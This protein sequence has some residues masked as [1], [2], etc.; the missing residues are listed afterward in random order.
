MFV[1]R[2]LP[3]LLALLALALV[4]ACSDKKP[5]IVEPDVVVAGLQRV[6][7]D[8]LSS[9]V[10]TE[11]TRLTVRALDIDGN[12]VSGVGVRFFIPNNG[13]GELD[14]SLVFT[15]SDGLATSGV[16]TLGTRS[17]YQH[18]RVHS[19]LVATVFTAIALPEAAVGI[20]YFAGNRQVALANTAVK[21][22]PAV[23]AIDRFG[24]GVPNVPVQFQPTASSVDGSHAITDSMGVASVARWT[25]GEA[26]PLISLV[27]TSPN[28][29]GQN[30]HFEA[31]VVSVL[32]NI[33]TRELVELPPRL[34]QALDRAI[35]RWMS[36]LS[37]HSGMSRAILAP[38]G[39]GPGSPPIDETITDLM[40]MIRHGALDGPG[41]VLAAAAPCAYHEETG[42]P[43]ISRI[44]FDSADTR[45]YMNNHWIDLIA[46]HELAHAL[47]FGSIW[48][49]QGLLS[50]MGTTDPVFVGTAAAREFQSSISG[51]SGKLVP[52]ENSG[53]PGTAD[54]HWR[55]TVFQREIM[56]G[57][58][59]SMFSPLSRIT[60]G[61]MEDMG[62]KVAY[63]G[64]DP[65]P[66][67]LASMYDA[68]PVQ[69]KHVFGNPFEPVVEPKVM[70]MVQRMRR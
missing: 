52:L 55:S 64:A 61:A 60:V 22:P 54:G 3:P 43:V 31:R 7:G 36:V 66:S 8:S 2:R 23:R 16:W 20:E 10:G 38:G 6:G 65:Y 70:P 49:R 29:P 42:L 17:G 26:S 40:V 32:Y 5:G 9:I 11:H 1:P 67:V 33:E 24:N 35:A 68:A 14:T 13:E 34:R 56:T 57:F 12:P 48:D 37:D 21:V 51:Y 19:Q 62:Y 58:V 63:E 69:M 30:V 47:G 41:G 25:L 28:F 4:S 50:G 39:C 15:D 45:Q 59:T 27:A 46:T 44:S 18:A 53:G